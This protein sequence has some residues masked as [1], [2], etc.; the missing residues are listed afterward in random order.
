MLST[1]CD[2]AGKTKVNARPKGS[3]R[4]QTNTKPCCGI[5]MLRC[6]FVI[7]A[8]AMIIRVIMGAQNAF[9]GPFTI[10]Y[11]R[12]DQPLFVRHVVCGPYMSLRTRNG[13]RDFQNDQHL[14]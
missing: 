13:I 9:D 1:L 10:A 6:P 3:P 8:L 7:I 5:M 14:L 12:Y 4:N 2:F 11:G